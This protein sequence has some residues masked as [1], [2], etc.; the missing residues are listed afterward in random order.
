MM[1]GDQR[2]IALVVHVPQPVANPR[3][4]QSAAMV[5]QN[6][7]FNQFAFKRPIFV[8]RSHLQFIAGLLVDRNE[9]APCPFTRR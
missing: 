2:N 9:P 4:R 3:Q 5:L 1:N 7:R 8:A 6:F